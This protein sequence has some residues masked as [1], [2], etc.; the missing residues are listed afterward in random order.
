MNDTTTFKRAVG[1]LA[2]HKGKASVT[3][4]SV[5]AALVSL[6]PLYSAKQATTKEFADRWIAYQDNRVAD[7][8]AFADLKAKVD[9]LLKMNHLSVVTATNTTTE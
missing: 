5:V 2:E 6:A 1:T 7:A 4:A 3:L 9:L 8:K